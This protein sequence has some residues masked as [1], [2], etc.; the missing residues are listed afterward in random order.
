MSHGRG[1]RACPFFKEL[2]FTRKKGT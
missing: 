1:T 2:Y